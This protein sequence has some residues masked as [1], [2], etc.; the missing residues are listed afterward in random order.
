[1]KPT[2]S[3]EAF[4]NEAFNSLVIHQKCAKTVNHSA[5]PWLSRPLS[6]LQEIIKRRKV[7]DNDGQIGREN[8]HLWVSEIR[9]SSLIASS[10]WHSKKFSM[11]ADNRIAGG[12]KQATEIWSELIKKKT[13]KFSDKKGS[14]GIFLGKTSQN[15]SLS[16]EKKKIF[17]AKTF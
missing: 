9:K 6:C 1:M 16:V 17:V 10:I 13:N 5:T 12:Q 7:P 14:N 11:P 8:V 4:M 15:K 3:F 2:K